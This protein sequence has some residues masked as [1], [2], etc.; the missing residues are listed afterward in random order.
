MTLSLFGGMIGVIAGVAGARLTTVIAGWPTI[1]SFE[2]SR[3][4]VFSLA[5]GLFFGLYPANKAAPE[6]DRGASLRIAG[7]KRL[8]DVRCKRCCL[9]E[10]CRDGRVSDRPVQTLRDGSQDRADSA[11]GRLWVLIG[12]VDHERDDIKV[13]PKGHV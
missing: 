11:W 9:R 5:V 1:I 3:R 4:P 7:G 12:E 10:G 6:S 8:C 2:S 13:L